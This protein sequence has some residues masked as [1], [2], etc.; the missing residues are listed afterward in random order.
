MTTTPT[1]PAARADGTRPP[2]SAAP[3]RQRTPSPWSTS[4]VVVAVLVAFGLGAATGAALQRD[5]GERTTPAAGAPAAG[6]PGTTRDLA[7]LPRREEGDPLALGDVDAPVVVVEYADFRC[8]YCGAFAQTTFPE[9][10]RDY[11]DTGKV[12]YEWR[13]APVLGED[14]VRAAVAG[15]AAAAQGL[16]WEYADVLYAHTY[17]GGGDYGRETLVRL[18]GQVE[19]LDVTAFDTALDD[20]DLVRAVAQEAATT[21]ALGISSTPTF[22]IGDQV[23]QGAQ[24]VEVFRQ[25]LDAQW[26]A[27]QG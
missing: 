6:A 14:S 1:P 11:V 5:A 12:R 17:A 9:I 24:P 25:A 26:E 7:D 27:A 20:P 8:G 4:A 23:V 13:D 15:R 2:A 21:Q 3:R 10:V 22:V 18:A 19:G 16:F